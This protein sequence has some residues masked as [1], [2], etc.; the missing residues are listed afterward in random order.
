[1]S[2]YYDASF[3]SLNGIKLSDTHS[4][5]VLGCKDHNHLASIEFIYSETVAVL[6]QCELLT[7]PRI[8]QKSLK[9]FWNEFLDDLKEKSCF[10]VVFGRTLGAHVQGNFFE[11]SKLRV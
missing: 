9:P 8:P 10:G 3:Q 11:S 7:V 2:E 6:Q 4:N 5:C 1:M